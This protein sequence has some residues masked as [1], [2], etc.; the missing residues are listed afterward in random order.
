M[1][2]PLFLQYI[3]LASILTKMLRIYY[4]GE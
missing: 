1:Y 3:L 2:T 4:I